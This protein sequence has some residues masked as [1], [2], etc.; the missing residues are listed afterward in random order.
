QDNVAINA[1]ALQLGTLF[2]MAGVEVSRGPVGSGPYRNASAGAIK[3]ESRKP[4][5]TYNGYLRS[6]FG[7][8]NYQDFEGAIEA[9]IFEDVLSGRIAFRT[10]MRDGW[11][12]N[13][14]GDPPPNSLRVR[15]P[16][17]P[18][19]NQPDDPR[20]SLCGEAVPF[21]SVSPIPEDNPS[22]VNNLN[23]WATRA[24]LR[25]EP[26]LDQEWL[27]NG[28]VANRDELSTQGLSYGT[29]GR[30][31]YPDN[32]QI[33]GTLG[34][35]DAGG[36]VRPDVQAQI[37]ALRQLY[38]IPIRSV[39]GAS[40][41]N[42]QLSQ[43]FN[44]ASIETANSIGPNL[45]ADY[46]TGFYNAPGDTR[47][48]TYGA[49]LSGEIALPEDLTFKTISGYDRY[50][51]FLASDTDQSPNT[52]FEI[53]TDDEGWQ[54]FQDISIG[55]PVDA[56]GA[57]WEVGGFYLMEALD[58]FIDND[59]GEL[60]AAN[61]AAREYTQDTWSFGIYSQFDFEFWD[62]FTLD[63][64]IRY[65]WER[66]DIDYTLVRGNVVTDQQ[67]R[68]ES[69]PT[70]TLRLTYNFREDSHAYWKYTRGWKGGHYNATASLTDGVTYADPEQN[71]AYE[72]GLRAAW[73]DARLNLDMSLFYYDYNNY[74][75]FTIS[76]SFGA[77]PE[78]VV[79]NAQGVNIFGS[80]VEVNGRPW[81]G[82]F[83]LVRFGWLES[84]FSD[85]VQNQTV[86]QQIPGSI[87]IVRD[88]ELNFTGNRLL[89]SPRFT[90]SMTFEQTVQLG[91]YGSLTGRYDTAWTDTTFFDATEGRGLPN[92]DD[93][94]ILP[95]DTIGQKPYWLHNM[96]LTYRPPIG[97]VALEF[98]VRNLT[99]Q[100]YRNFSFDAAQ[101]QRTTIHFIGEPR[102]FGAT[103]SI[104]FE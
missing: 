31:R 88:I 25:F 6:S 71:N 62:D 74:Q 17:P 35:E 21:F 103:F 44:R 20:W 26:T 5:G 13:G 95:N 87:A 99:N 98:Y 78:F 3:L 101:F 81:D 9:P 66:K 80:E 32:S 42:T 16:F 96:L 77:N 72:T 76:N 61:V 91:R 69:A 11:M 82:A 85:F 75:L 24:T 57:D 1:P 89:N 27:L 45:S 100:A 63:G 53:T 41:N 40:C 37:E 36:F 7:N 104:Q 47:N 2:D 58:V 12:R 38:L 22:Y 8:F 43:A 4:S 83:A 52:I 67:S 51:R 15:R 54:F 102:T 68:T 33:D 65:N 39:C 49:Y 46:L 48:L 56:W 84:T 64:G 70:G 92:A 34:G 30:Q 93:Q 94:L 86:Q 90:I 50:D 19:Q 14:C 28:H 18:P 29:Q 97:N 59:F 10:S 55:G 79:I 23:N 73:F 60:A